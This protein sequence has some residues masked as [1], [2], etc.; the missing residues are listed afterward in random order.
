MFPSHIYQRQKLRY[1]TVSISPNHCLVV[2][3]HQMEAES[4]T[5]RAQCFWFPSVGEQYIHSFIHF[6]CSTKI[7]QTR[8]TN[9]DVLLQQIRWSKTQNFACGPG[10]SDSACLNYVKKSGSQLVPQNAS[11]TL[12]R[13]IFQKSH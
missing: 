5:R 4:I 3:T 2:Y 7:N 6:I 1:T 12:F 11:R 9:K 10:L 8:L 13:A